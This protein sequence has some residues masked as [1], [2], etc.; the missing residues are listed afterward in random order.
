M[1]MLAAVQAAPIYLDRGATVEKACDLIGKAGLKGADLVAFGETW[2]P[3]YPF[4][5]F[6]G[7]SRARWEA[8]EA[9]LAQ[10]VEI[11]GSETDQLCTAARAAGTDVRSASRNSTVGRVVR[12]TAPCSSSAEKVRFWAATESSSPLW[13][14]GSFGARGPATI[15]TSTNATVG[16]AR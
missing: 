8:A 10:A 2:L 14:S 7:P 16:S 1:F 13:T 9:Y 6:S 3:G 11:P 5:A 15:S 4:F 12:S